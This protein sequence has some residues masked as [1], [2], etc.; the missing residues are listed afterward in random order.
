MSCDCV[1]P[2]CST[3]RQPRARRT[4]RCCECAQPIAPGERYVRI[5]GIWDGSP[6]SH[7]FCLRCD[8][9]RA[10]LEARFNLDCGICFGGLLETIDYLL[11]DV[12][13]G[14]GYRNVIAGPGARDADEAELFGWALWLWLGA[15]TDSYDG[16]RTRL[17]EWRA[18]KRA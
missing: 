9:L 13:A 17:A 8:R 4:H 15:R 3:V 2:S 5:S 6:A 1:E 12:I 11:S 16:S 14:I 7:A 18:R 10:L